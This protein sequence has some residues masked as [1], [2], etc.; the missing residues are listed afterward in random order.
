MRDTTSLMTKNNLDKEIYMID[1]DT[2]T[3]QLQEGDIINFK[4]FHSDR[5]D[6]KK[7][8]L[9]IEGAIIKEIFPANEPINREKLVEIYGEELGDLDYLALSTS[10]SLRLLLNLGFN[11]NNEMNIKMITVN[12]DFCQMGYQVID[13]TGS[14]QGLESEPNYMLSQG[15][16][17]TNY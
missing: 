5:H 15:L 2:L 10:N 1:Y 17:N 9:D 16:W 7:L 6:R 3:Q 8:V 11:Q 13:K 4:E 12:K 14:L